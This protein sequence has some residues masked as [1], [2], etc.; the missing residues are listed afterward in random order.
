MWEVIGNDNEV[1]AEIKGLKSTRTD[2]ENSEAGGITGR[3]IS[4]MSVF[5]TCEMIENLF[6]TPLSKYYVDVSICERFLLIPNSK[7]TKARVIIRTMRL[8]IYKII[9]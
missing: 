8:I 3:H 7:T 4:F 1:K 5:C 9:P 2:V 6:Q